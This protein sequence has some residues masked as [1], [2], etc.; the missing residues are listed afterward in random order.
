MN[1]RK[2][3][4]VLVLL[5][6]VAGGLVYVFVVNKPHTNVA[7]AEAA[8]EGSATGLYAEFQADAAAAGTRY[9]GKVVQVRGV[10]VEIGGTDG[11]I[12]LQ[13][14]AGN[15]MGGG[16]TAAL[17]DSENTAAA[18][19]EPGQEVVVR[20]ECSGLDQDEGGLLGALGATVQ[21]TSCILVY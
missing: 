7:K 2:I 6:A 12:N 21:L 17:A 20:G 8:Y 3:L 14:E 13:L 10:L 5:G 4:G 18:A 19:L 11:S 1:I 9:A 16:L 15:P